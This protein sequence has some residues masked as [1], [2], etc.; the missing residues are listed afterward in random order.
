MSNGVSA[1]SIVREKSFQALYLLSSRDELSVDDAIIQTLNTGA[2]TD[3]DENPSVK[4]LLRM[5]MPKEY[6]SDRIVD[7]SYYFLYQLVTGVQDE[8]ESIDQTIGKHLKSRS[9]H[10]LE[11]S[12]LI[13]L[14]LAIF[15]LNSDNDVAPSIILDEAIELTKRFNDDKSGK[16]VN[17][18]LQSVLNDSSAE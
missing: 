2:Q 3:D 13:A 17:G 9:I 15:E 4:E 5:N 1:R 11:I 7:D 18:V 10:R 8:C 6:R 12:N 16:F 14:R